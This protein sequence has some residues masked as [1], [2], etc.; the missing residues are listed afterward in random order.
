MLLYYPPT[1]LTGLAGVTSPFTYS[2]SENSEF[3]AFLSIVS[4]VQVIGVII[5]KDNE[6]FSAIIL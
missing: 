5:K 6:K 3:R 1:S 4:F 2:D